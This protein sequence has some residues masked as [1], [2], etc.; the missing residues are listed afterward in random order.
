M[1]RNFVF[2]AFLFSKTEGMRSRVRPNEV[3]G[4]GYCRNHFSKQ[5][6]RHTFPVISKAQNYRECMETKK[7]Y[8]GIPK[9]RYQ[10]QFISVVKL[11]L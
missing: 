2:F 5:S 7:K 8:L 11:N 3:G 6:F 1:I 9:S 10:V 4:N